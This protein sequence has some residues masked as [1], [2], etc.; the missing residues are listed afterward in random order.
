MSHTHEQ[1]G[2]EDAGVGRLLTWPSCLWCGRGGS[3][4]MGYRAMSGRGGRG[5]YRYRPY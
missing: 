5:E 1:E 3:Y 4:D 2:D